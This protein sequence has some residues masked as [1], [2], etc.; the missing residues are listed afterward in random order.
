M[1]KIKGHIVCL[2]LLFNFIGM[3]GIFFSF[4]ID[5]DIT[6]KN[7]F[8]SQ[9][10][11]QQQNL[12]SNNITITIKEKVNN[13]QNYTIINNKKDNQN[14]YLSKKNN[15]LRKLTAHLSYDI[16]IFINIVPI[17]FFI[18]IILSF[19]VNY[20]KKDCDGNFSTINLDNA[21]DGGILGVIF[22]IIFVIV[23]I[24][25]CLVIYGITVGL[26]KILG[27]HVS[28]IFGLVGI[29]VCY[30]GIFIYS[31]ILLFDDIYKIK[32]Y[33]FI[34]ISMI[35]VII[36]I[37][38]IILPCSNINEHSEIKNTLSNNYQSPNIKEYQ[39][40]NSDFNNSLTSKNI[41]DT[42]INFDE[43]SNNGSLST[44]LNEQNKQNNEN[45]KISNYGMAPLPTDFQKQ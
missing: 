35:L 16:I 2:L 39:N 11:I 38:G 27:K 14:Q 17:Y 29:I 25:I 22:L 8:S 26:T 20:N 31:I 18:I 9:I 42:P 43:N 30:I 40:N 1:K 34:G 3:I 41:I 37:I 21:G 5:D 4:F 13:I 6:F 23:L 15:N 19:L 45:E 33:V 36:N 28:Q 12:S 24:G 10:N 7:I 44:P 32:I